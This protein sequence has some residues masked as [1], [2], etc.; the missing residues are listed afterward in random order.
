MKHSKHTLLSRGFTLIE[1]MIVVAIIGI[2]AAIAYPSYTQ[3]MVR[4][5]RSAAMQLML[6]IASREEQYVLDARA[7]TA[8]L[9]GAN[10]VRLGGTEESFTCSANECVN[11]YYTV[12]VALVTGPPAGYT[13]TATARG[14][15]TSD[16]NLTLDSLGAKTPVDK[17]QK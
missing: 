7:Y 12:A 17:W 13:I 9:T 1:L 10:S 16:D 8:T 14:T 4:A 3:Y 11:P 5:H 15:Q 6:K 2:L